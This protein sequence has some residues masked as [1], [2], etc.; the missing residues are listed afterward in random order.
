MRNDLDDEIAADYHRKVRNLPDVLEPES[1]NTVVF[2]PP[3]SVH[4][5]NEHYGGRQVA[6]NR[7]MEEAID[8]LLAPQGRV[9]TISY[10]AQGM[11]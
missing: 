4:K 5:A 9:L 3:W 8:E 7:V 6:V 2:D 10:M 11:P 1:F